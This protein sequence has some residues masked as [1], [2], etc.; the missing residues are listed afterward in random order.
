VDGPLLVPGIGAQGGTVDDVRRIFGS[1]AG[2]VLPSSSREVLAAGPDKVRL[3]DA[4]RHTV[5]GFASL[6]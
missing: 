2:Q 6:G 5:D 4:A 1:S 3:R